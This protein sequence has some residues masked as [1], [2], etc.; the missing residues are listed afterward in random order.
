[1]LGIQFSSDIWYLY[2]EDVQQEI[3]RGENE[4]KK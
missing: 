2:M 1:M 3:I 4:R